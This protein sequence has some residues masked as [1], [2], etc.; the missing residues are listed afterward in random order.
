MGNSSL[1]L[2]AEEAGSRCWRTARACRW[3]ARRSAPLRLA[4]RADDPAV[5][6]TV[7]EPNAPAE[8]VPTGRDWR[9]HIGKPGEFKFGP[10]DVEAEFQIASP[11]GLHSP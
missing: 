10:Y 7:Q 2:D 8:L 1:L 9:R 3:S 6:G 4:L 5:S 11:N